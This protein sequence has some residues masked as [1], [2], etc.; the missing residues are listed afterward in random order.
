MVNFLM[1][2][3][4]FFSHLEISKVHVLSYKLELKK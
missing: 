2:F 1:I 3:N 4:Q